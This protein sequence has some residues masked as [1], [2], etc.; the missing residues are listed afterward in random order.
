MKL[1]A[2]A[3]SIVAALVVAG[4]SLATH[5]YNGGAAVTIISKGPDNPGGNAYCPANTIV[6]PKIDPGKNYSDQYIVISGFDGTT[7]D[8]DFTALGN[9]TYDMAIVIVKG[10]PNSAVYTYDFTANPAFDDGDDNLSPPTN[11]KNG[12]DYGVSHIQVC[13]DPKGGGDN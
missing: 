4:V 13:Y 6:G 11:P 5:E 2:L 1:L 9:T 8:W 7:F 3:G 10:G 12:K